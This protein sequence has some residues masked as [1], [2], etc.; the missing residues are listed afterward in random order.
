MVMSN[1]AGLKAR[2]T[3]SSR[4]KWVLKRLLGREHTD[5]HEVG[6][7][8]GMRSRTLQRRIAEE[9]SSFRQLLS[10]ARRE[11]ARIYLQH[12]SLGL[13][14]TASLLGYEDPKSFLR[15]FRMWERVTPTEWRARQR[16]EC[17][18]RPPD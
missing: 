10:D 4:A 16:R 15:A 2:Q 8:L 18:I 14:K 12:P 3:T 17:S 1:I 5:I 7:E 9:G 6:R 13:S 11:L